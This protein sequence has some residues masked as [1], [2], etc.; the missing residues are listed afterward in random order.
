MPKFN[1]SKTSSNSSLM[2]SFI[3]SGWSRSSTTT[4]TAALLSSKTIASLIISSTAL[5]HSLWCDISL[6]FVINA[7]SVLALPSRSTVVPKA[8]PAF[9]SIVPSVFG[10][11]AK[12]C[13]VAGVSSSLRP[14]WKP[15]SSKAILILSSLLIGA[16]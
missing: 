16:A 6:Y 2:R 5:S 9:T 4:S 8:P 14:I 3:A 10:G 15:K 7:T 11:G 13:T 1:K 12:D